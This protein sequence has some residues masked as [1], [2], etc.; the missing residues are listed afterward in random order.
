MDGLTDCSDV[1]ESVLTEWKQK[2]IIKIDKKHKYT[3]S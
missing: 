2:V 3:V 1:D